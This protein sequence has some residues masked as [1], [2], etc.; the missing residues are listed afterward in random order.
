MAGEWPWRELTPPCGLVLVCRYEGV[1]VRDGLLHGGGV[2]LL[3][4]QL[5]GIV[6]VLAMD[7]HV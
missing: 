1:E 2:D 5:L 6:V 7:D 4:A 3:L